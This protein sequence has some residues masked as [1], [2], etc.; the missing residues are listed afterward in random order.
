M[1]KQRSKPFRHHT[2]HC[3]LI[4]STWIRRY[5]SIRSSRHYWY[6]FDCSHQC[7]SNIHWRLNK[8][9]AGRLAIQFR[10][11][12]L[13][14]ERI[15]IMKIAVLSSVSVDKF[16]DQCTR[17][18]VERHARNAS[19]RIHDLAQWDVCWKSRVTWAHKSHNC[20]DTDSIAAL[21]V[22][23]WFID[24]WITKH[25]KPFAVQL[26]KCAPTFKVK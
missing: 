6:R 4:R 26:W 25:T 18:E 7:L 11:V 23:Q 15:R 1:R 21:E 8:N 20:F 17:R 22:G 10:K 5:K 12:A 16:R 19:H 13:K 9:H 2:H 24:V 14:N 3:T